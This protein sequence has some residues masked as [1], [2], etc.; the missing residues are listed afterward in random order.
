MKVT[1]YNHG[2]FKLD[3]GA[4][5]GSVPK[6]IWN[7]LISADEQNRILLALGSLIIETKD[8]KF[9][10]DVGMGDK[11][12][13][14]Q[15]GIYDI[16]NSPRNKILDSVTD[17]ILTHLHFDHAGG[18]SKHNKEGKLEAAFPGAK[19]H[20]QRANLEN[21]GKPNRKEKASYL[22]E[23]VSALDFYDL[24]V[25]D[26]DVE[27]FPGITVHKIDGHTVG[28]Q[29]IEIVINDNAKPYKK[30][31]FTTDLIPTHH[32]AHPGF[33]MA[34][35]MQA[36]KILEEKEQVLKRGLKEDAIIVFQHDLQSPFG[37]VEV[38]EKGDYN[39]VKASL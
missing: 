5:F 35:D 11:W 24:N 8:R 36:L 12:S 15:I 25:V 16:K 33:S 22:L 37:K 20:I 26:G 30:I 7:K 32:H 13:E 18:I 28:Q 23:N 21:A 39:I 17:V 4:M 38:T 29:W 34:Y 6:N 31:F 1:Y 19:V 27:I 14:K 3:G 9:L 10:I 2:T